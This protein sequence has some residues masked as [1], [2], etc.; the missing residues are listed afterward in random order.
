MTFSSSQ[1]EEH[2]RGSGWLAW[3]KCAAG[4]REALYGVFGREREILLV[5]IRPSSV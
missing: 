4:G 1:K 5:V 3:K 2:W